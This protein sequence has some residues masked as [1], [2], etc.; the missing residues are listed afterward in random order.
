TIKYIDFGSGPLPEYG[1]PSEQGAG[2]IFGHP[3]AESAIAVGAVP[4]FQ[5]PAFGN[6]DPILEDFSSYG[7]IPVFYDRFGNRIDP[8]VRQ[9]PEVCG[10]DGVN[11]SF[12]FPF[13][14]I[15]D[16]G[17][18]NFLERPLRLPT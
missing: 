17:F 12:F 1:A 11:T 3:N 16:D 10:P 13:N 7:G 14:D 5:T 8:L 4:Y 18:P 9:K 2:T 6:P 15:E